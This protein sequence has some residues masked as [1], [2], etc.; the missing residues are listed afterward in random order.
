MKSMTGKGSVRCNFLCLFLFLFSVGVFI[1]FYGI[2]FTSYFIIFKQKK[3]Q[4]FF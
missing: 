2:I 4:R 3:V 1:T